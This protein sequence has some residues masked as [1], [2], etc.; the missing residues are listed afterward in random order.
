MRRLDHGFRGLAYSGALIALMTFCSVAAA[1]ND[2]DPSAGAGTGVEEPVQAPQP[3]CSKP[4][5]DVPEQT[6]ESRKQLVKKC[7]L[8]GET[9]IDPI[10]CV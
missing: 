3:V 1:Q 4:V 5:I 10:Q 2:E 7:V 6:C 9:T 8:N